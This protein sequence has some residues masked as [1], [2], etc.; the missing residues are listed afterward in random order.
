M[1]SQSGNTWI[2]VLIALAVGGVIGYALT[3]MPGAAPA[4]SE[5]QGDH[6]SVE[7]KIQNAM[8]A[9][10]ESVS[11]DATVLDWPPEAGKDFAVLK[12]GSNGWTC[13]PDY[14]ASPGNDPLCVDAE[15]MKWF[16]A[17][18]SQTKPVL[19]QAGL[20]YM[21]QGGSDPSNADPY[22]TEPAPGEQWMS[23]PAHVMLFP[24][25][26]PDPKVYGTNPDS[27]GPWVMWANTPYAHLMM[28]VK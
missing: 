7:W 12:E 25:T 22:A 24:T 6:S 15:A 5:I 9:A 26:P 2:L 28:P 13:I 27:G 20:A 8:S 21:L 17:Y 19:A 4:S 23:A 10:P 18:M 1:N 11:K 16:Q 14:P 3:G